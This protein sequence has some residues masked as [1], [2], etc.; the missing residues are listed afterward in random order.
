VNA[1]VEALVSGLR[2]ALGDNLV[3]IYLHGSLAL[4]CFNPKRSDIDVLV[5][6]GHPLADEERSRVAH[7]L[8]RLS[9]DPNAIELSTLARGYLE[10]WRHPSPYDFHFGERRRSQM[11]RGDFGTSGE[12]DVDLAAHVTVA[13]R[14]GVALHGPAPEIVFPPV[15]REDYAE[16]LLGDLEWTLAEHPTDLYGALSPARVWAGIAEPD[17]LHTKESAASW[18]LARVPPEHRAVL[19]H[20]LALY[21]GERDD[22]LD[23][24]AVRAWG[25]FAAERVEELRDAEAAATA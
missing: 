22:E 20:A 16:S 17:A 2:D 7:T 1:Q 13:R 4:G 10:P 24:E 5:V 18:A 15:P 8:L 19:D 14:A 23:P 12:T 6:T 3:G 21:R 9:G 11:E 25:V